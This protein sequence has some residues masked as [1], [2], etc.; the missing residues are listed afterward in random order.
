MVGLLIAASVV[1]AGYAENAAAQPER[2]GKGIRSQALSLR[3]G[4]QFTH[5]LIAEQGKGG[6]AGEQ[7][8][9][10]R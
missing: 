8:P 4:K 9:S 5:V 6:Q 1:G 10:R 7:P 3:S 2:Y